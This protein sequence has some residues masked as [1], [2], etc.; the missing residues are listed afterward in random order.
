MET[1]QVIFNTQWISVKQSHRGFQYLERKGKDSVAVFL[2]NKSS[3]H[4]KQYEV[5]IRQQH[6]CVDNREVD[7]MFRLF[8]CPVTGALEEGEAPE[9]AAKREVYEETGYRVQVL[10]LGQYIVGTQVNEICYLYYADVTGINPHVA[11]QDGT[12][13]E[14][15][16]KN[17]WHPFEYL[18]TC[19]YSACQIGYWKLQ[20]ILFKDS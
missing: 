13:M 3:E 19:D 11:Q 14:S 16:A 4:P 18:E 15:I 5:L 6:L 20:K 1:D 8:P 9:A 12:Y 2:L 7:E 10:P 17:E